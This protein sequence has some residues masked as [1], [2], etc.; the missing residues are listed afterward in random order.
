[1]SLTVSVNQGPFK[2]QIPE[3]QTGGSFIL[4]GWGSCE[5]PT[6]FTDIF[7][8]HQEPHNGAVQSGSGHGP[9]N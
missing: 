2:V 8:Q 3:G 1:M 4:V 9:P 6:K 7:N 5:R